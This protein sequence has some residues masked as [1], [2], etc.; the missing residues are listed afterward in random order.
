MDNE[1]CFGFYNT[2]PLWLKEQFGV[3]QFEFPNLDL[4]NFKP[5]ALNE[6]LRLGHQ[7]EEVCA[8]L[9]TLSENWTIIAKNVLVDQEK[10]RL[11]ELDFIIQN[12]RKNTIHHVELAYKFYIVNPEISEPIHSLMGPNKRDMFYTKLDKLKEKQFPLLYADALIQ[13]LEIL[14]LNPN[15]IVQEACFKTQ[16]FVP[17]NNEKVS[18]R[19]LNKNCIVG[20]WIHFEDFNSKEFKGNEYYIPSKRE[21]IIAP[22]AERHYSSHYETLLDINMRMLKENAPMVWVKRQ[23]GALEKLFV[24]WW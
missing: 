16:L 20:K 18:I 19:P 13:Q 11:G 22:T 12:R 2:S 3:S 15:Q 21:W 17:Y 7:M 1:L 5:D 10:I 24:V 23:D 14:R 6:N 9:L 8:Q 4:V